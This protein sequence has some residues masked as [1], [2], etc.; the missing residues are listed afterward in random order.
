MSAFGL[1]IGTGQYW[2][3]LGEFVGGPAGEAALGMARISESLSEAA[4][5][6]ADSVLSALPKA[7]RTQRDFL[8]KKLA[9][10]KAFNSYRES[11]NLPI[12]PYNAGE[13]LELIK[14]YGDLEAKMKSVRTVS[15]RNKPVTMWRGK[16]KASLGNSDGKVDLFERN[17]WTREGENRY[18]LGGKD[19]D[20]GVY[21]VIGDSEG[22]VRETIEMEM[23]IRKENGK[24][25]AGEEYLIQARNFTGDR[26][27]D[28]TDPETLT[29]LGIMDA[30]LLTRRLDR[31][32]SAYDLPQ[33]IGNL[34]ILNGFD[35]IKYP[36]AQ[37]DRG[38]CIVLLK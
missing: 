37:K 7:S 13:I 15:F 5:K 38:V 33:A 35:A 14:R 29:H 16:R 23:R 20:D 34:A 24:L 28:L 11:K 25:A 10:I 31:D 8:F 2:R 32:M 19:G 36:S 30:D 27:L 1:F 21:A 4:R 3:K 12:R 9:S 18:T 26:V 17:K 6:T 22:E